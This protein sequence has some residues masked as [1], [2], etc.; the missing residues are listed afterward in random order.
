MAPDP[1]V[2][3]DRLSIHEPL[4]GVYDAPNPAPFE[5][6]VAPKN[7][8]CIFASYN[9]WRKGKT[10][11]LTREQ[12]GCF[13]SG[14][15]LGLPRRPREQM[16]EFL[17]GE[18]GLRATPELMGA[19]WDS[20]PQYHPKNDHL[21]IGPLQADQYELLLTVTFLVNPDQLSVLATGA[22]YYSR[23]EDIP[24][25][26]APFGS[27]CMMALSLFADLDAP[28]AIIGA[29]DQAMRKYLKPWMMAFTVTR[30]MYERL[31]DWAADKRSSLHTGFLEGLI[32][33]R[34]GSLGA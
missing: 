23:P 30:P 5:P 6:L 10:L 2:I 29:T 33:A 11:H 24:P 14:H 1:A 19:W 32:K 13:G 34:G 25:V 15:I 7:R 18:E 4:V 17:W 8:E 27:G 26:I 31:C 22:G 12:Y 16:V 20:A 3:L 21:L 9:A 28:Q